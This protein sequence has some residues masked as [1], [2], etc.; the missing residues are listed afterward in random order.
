[1]RL[2]QLGGAAGLSRTVVKLS[3]KRALNSPSAWQSKNHKH[4]FCAASKEIERHR[5]HPRHLAL[6]WSSVATP[7]HVPA[8]S[9]EQS[10]G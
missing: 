1:L 3:A 10:P 6:H 9:R 4:S 5:A 7:V 8:R 2:A